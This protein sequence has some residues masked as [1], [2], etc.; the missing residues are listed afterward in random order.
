[1]LPEAFPAVHGSDCIFRLQRELRVQK[2]IRK[3]RE[4]FLIKK[5]LIAQYKT[6]VLNSIIS[7]RLQSGPPQYLD[8]CFY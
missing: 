3:T 7:Y 4:K 8:S 2:S 6:R 5:I 1:M